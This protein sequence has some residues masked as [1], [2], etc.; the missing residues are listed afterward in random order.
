MNIKKI[1]D[2]KYIY[3]DEDA[4][5]LALEAERLAYI[6]GNIELAEAYAFIAELLDENLDMFNELD[7]SLDK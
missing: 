1:R 5:Q 6:N 2:S 4:I 7:T 3:Y